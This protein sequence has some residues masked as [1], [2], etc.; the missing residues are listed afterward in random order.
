MYILQ[1]R[2]LIVTTN[3]TSIIDIYT[4]KKKNLKVTLK[5]IIKS[6]QKRVKEDRNNKNKNTTKTT[7]NQTKWQ[8]VHIY[9]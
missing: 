4:H 6:Q 1:Y 5:V 8:L 9:Q 3:Q 7:Q 2:N